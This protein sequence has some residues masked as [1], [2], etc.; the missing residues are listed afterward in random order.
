MDRKSYDAIMGL[1]RAKKNIILQG[2][3]GVRARP[4]RRAS[5]T[6]DGRRRP[7]VMLVQFRQSYSYEAS[8]GAGSSRLSVLLLSVPPTTKRAILLLSSTRSTVLSKHF[9]RAVPLIESDKREVNSNFLTPASL[10][11]PQRPHTA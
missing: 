2:A 4:S 7:R 1:L 3:P 11:A 9:R 10:R 5:R 8:R 6:D